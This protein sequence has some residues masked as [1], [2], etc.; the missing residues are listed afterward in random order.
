VTTSEARPHPAETGSSV[1][2]TLRSAQ[3]LADD[4]LS[5]STAGERH[6]TRP[7]LKIRRGYTDVLSATRRKDIIHG[8]IEID[9]TH[10]HHVLRERKSAGEDLSFTA[11][12]I[13]A[14]AQAVTEDRIM[15][16]YRRRNRLVLF[17]DVDVNAQIETEVGGQRI[18]K[19]L[20][21]RSA[22]SKS[23]TELSAEIRAG[24]RHDPAGERRYRG[25]LTFL[26]LPRLVRA[27]AWR[28]VL[29]SPI[30]FKRLGGTVGVSSV[31]M[32]GPAGGWGIPIA[33]PTLMVTIGGLA[34]KPRYV[35]GVLEP[36]ELLD[37]TI[38]VDHAIVDGAPAARFAR[39]LTE[40]IDQADGLARRA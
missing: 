40:L 2:P 8:L 34:T 6:Q 30:W 18:V 13:H 5:T 23:V 10:V 25:T 15:H 24:Q 39:R 35:D 19:S 14:V 9:V 26:S 36:R 16:A 11:F 31:G 28:F 7:F 32:F 27:L 22:N 21:I 29:G 20:L 12:V 1:R 17:D 3:P 4:T 37:V 33:P 38:S